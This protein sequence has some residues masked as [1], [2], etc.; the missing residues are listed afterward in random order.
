MTEKE[1]ITIITSTEANELRSVLAQFHPFDLASVFPKLK[2]EQK[3]QNN[4][5]IKC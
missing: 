5:S 4:K 3:E 1:I 2:S